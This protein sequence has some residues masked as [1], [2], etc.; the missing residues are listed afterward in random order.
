MNKILTPLALGAGLISSPV[1]SANHIDFLVDSGF[2]FSAV[3]TQ[4]APTTLTSS[5]DSGNVIRAERDI[6]LWADV[7]TYNA[8]LDAP[9]GPGAVGPKPQSFSKSL[10]PGQMPLPHSEPFA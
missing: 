10:L 8:V 1:A 7:G 2:D 3:D 4:V 9:V 6:T 5:G